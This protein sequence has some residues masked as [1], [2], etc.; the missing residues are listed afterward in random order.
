MYPIIPIIPV[1]AIL[2]SVIPILPQHIIIYCR[3]LVSFA[4]SRFDT[5]SRIRELLSCFLN[6]NIPSHKRGYMVVYMGIGEQIAVSKPGFFRSGHVSP[7]YPL[8]PLRCR[9]HNVARE[10]GYVSWRQPGQSGQSPRI[11]LLERISRLLSCM[12]DLGSLCTWCQGMDPY[13]RRS[14]H[15]R[16]YY[17][18]VIQG[19]KGGIVYWSCIG[20]MENRMETTI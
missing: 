11:L 2:C 16:L 6:L 18:G 7:M 4:V 3:E 9:V 10:S 19:Y 14:C 5:G 20:I 1:F 13:H 15:M 12:R 17:M 8:Q